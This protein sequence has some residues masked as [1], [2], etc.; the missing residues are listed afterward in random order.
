MKASF[1]KSNCPFLKLH[2]SLGEIDTNNKMT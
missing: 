1:M 2:F